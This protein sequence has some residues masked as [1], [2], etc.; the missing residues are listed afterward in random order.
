MYLLIREGLGQV[1]TPS[2]APQPRTSASQSCEVLD[3]FLFD[4]SSL[5]PFHT[6]QIINIASRVIASQST[7]QPVRLVRLIGFT[8]P[9]GTDVYNLGLG[10]R[11]AEEVKRHLR[12][13]IDQ[14]KPGLASRITFVVE[15]RGEAQPIPGS[16][17]HSRRVEVCVPTAPP[18]PPQV[19]GPDATDWFI[20]QVAAAKTDRDVVAVQADLAGAKR[21]AARFRFSADLIAEGAV[22]KKVLAEEARAGSPPRTPAATAQLAASVPGQRAFGRALVAATVPLTGAP[23]ALVLAAVRRAAL[24]WKALVQTGGRFDFKN[25]VRTMKKPR[26]ANCPSPTGCPDTITLCPSTSSDCFDSD[27][28]GNLFYAHVGRFAG[29][30]EL[31]LQLGSQFAELELSKAWDSPEDT[32][33]ISIGFGLPHPLT[34]AD[35][36]AALVT[37]RASFTLRPCANCPEVTTAQVV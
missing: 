10:G 6:P 30:T 34:R 28:P 23:E 2:R 24:R 15:S 19:C 5:R 1:P 9:T 37:H 35:L 13:T 25:D 29:W 7:S 22:A 3:R 18:P 33:M 4:K 11:R 14:M 20:R 8:D 17:E 31:A 27:V 32:R 12:N 26:S 21:V 16:P 36:C